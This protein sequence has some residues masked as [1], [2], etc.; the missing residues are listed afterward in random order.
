MCFNLTIHYL[1]TPLCLDLVI[2]PNKVSTRYVVMLTSE[3]HK[4]G[5]CLLNIG[6]LLS[7]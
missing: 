4:L 5:Y 1:M 3:K 7:P 2:H 6:P